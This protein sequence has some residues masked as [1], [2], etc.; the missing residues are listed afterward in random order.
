MNFELRTEN[1]E[2]KTR[3]VNVM[4]SVEVTLDESHTPDSSNGFTRRAF[5]SK[6][7]VQSSKF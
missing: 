1:F 3:D 4:L 7:E 5:S 2:L 6:F